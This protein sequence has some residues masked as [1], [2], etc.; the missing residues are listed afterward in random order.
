[1]KRLLLLDRDGVINHTSP[2]YIKKASEWKPIPGSLE[3]ISRLW[4]ANWRMIVVSNQSAIGRGLLSYEDLFEIH[5]KME[6]LLNATGARVEAFFFCPHLPRSH[7]DCRKPKTSLFT[8]IERRFNQSLNGVPFVGD[9]EKDIIA[10]RTMGAH[11]ILVLTGQGQK[12][13]KEVDDINKEDV[14]PDLAAVAKHLLLSEEINTE[15]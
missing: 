11:P 4:H 10:A 6:E 14:F 5:A 9:T 12:T 8:E 2:E 3:A 13:L 15:T 7:C 1:M